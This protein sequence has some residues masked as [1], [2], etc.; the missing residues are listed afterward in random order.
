MTGLFISF[1]GVDGVGKT[2]QVERLRDYLRGRGLI[3][4]TTREPGGTP[5]GVALRRLLLEGV[6]DQSEGSAQGGV[7]SS[8]QNNAQGS[9]QNDAQGGVQ[10]S[11]HN[12]TQGAARPA[13]IAPRAEALIFAADRAQHVA[14]VIRP[15]LRRG[16]VVVTD[17]Y[18]D[19][20]LAYQA[21]GRELTADEVRSLSMWATGDLLPDRT[22]LLDMDPRRSHA[23]LDHSEDRMESAGDDF[24]RRTRRAFLD[25]AAADPA[26]FV[27]VD[28]A[29][30]VDDVW[31]TIRAD[32]DQLIA[33]GCGDSRLRAAAEPAAAAASASAAAVAAAVSL[34]PISNSAD[35]VVDPV[36]SV[37]DSADAAADAA[38]SAS[39]ERER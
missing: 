17:R 20:S 6:M 2:T 31:R 36:D 26:R 18:I 32:V 11:A 8:A 27:V 25:L 4:R 24:Q 23:R 21:G 39:M 7:Q 12:D 9:T 5:L 3:V 37:D 14:E 1:E 28:A 33:D 34:N 29:G 10:N 16:E 15:A 22:Y 13:D 30:S 38:G 19:S 35:S